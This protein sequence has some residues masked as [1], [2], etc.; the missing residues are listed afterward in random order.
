MFTFSNG[1][2]SVDSFSTEKKARAYIKI[3]KDTNLD[4]KIN[5]YGEDHILF[6]SE[7]DC[8]MGSDRV[9]SSVMKLELNK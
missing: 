9:G 3:V 4:T 8:A 7:I 2:K 6:K 5:V 1:E